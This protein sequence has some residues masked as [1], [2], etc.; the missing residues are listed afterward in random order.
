MMI[1]FRSLKGLLVIAPI[2]LFG[3]SAAQADFLGVYVGAGVWGQD[4]AGSAVSDVSIEDQ[5]GLADN[6]GV[7]A[8]FRF[9]HP[10]PM[11]PNI[12]IAR[13]DIEDAG[14]GVLT[15]PFEFGG[16]AFVPGQSV[17]T[18]VDMTHTDVT[19][20]YEL[21]DL[22]F[23]LDLGLTTR[24]LDS[25]LTIDGVTEEENA[26]LPMLYAAGKVG[27]P[28][29]G[30]YLAGDINGLGFNGA[31]V[32]DYAVKVGWEI[33]NFILPEFGVEAGFR[34]F[35]IDAGDDDLDFVIDMDV[36]GVFFNITG[37]F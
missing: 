7:Q 22:A 6:S 12:R 27:L 9:E 34:R 20:Y 21:V 13:S 25:Q 37:H 32:M 16:D 3:T 33:E 19:L 11:L 28:F 17:T 4:F 23:D 15:S 14:V 5:L 31:S 36:E 29:S 18:T 1:F 30:F 24:V 2:T 10:V 35:A 26:V 8:Y